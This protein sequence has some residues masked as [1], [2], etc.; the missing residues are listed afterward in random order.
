MPRVTGTIMPE[1]R[2]FLQSKIL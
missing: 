2:R 1:R